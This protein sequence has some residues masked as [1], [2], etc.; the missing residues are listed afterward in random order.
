MVNAVAEEATALNGVN[1]S[2]ANPSS[3][4]CQ[5]YEFLHPPLQNILHTSPVWTPHVL[6]NF[7]GPTSVIGVSSVLPCHVCVKMVRL[8]FGLLHK[9]MSS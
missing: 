1:F 7:P 6:S 3:P 5:L 2:P 8:C 9:T 4:L